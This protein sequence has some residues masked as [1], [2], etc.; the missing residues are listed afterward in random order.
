MKVELDFLQRAYYANLL[1]IRAAKQRSIAE[2]RSASATRL[3][4]EA[5]A[6]WC[7]A[8]AQRLDDAFEEK[9]VSDKEPIRIKDGS[10]VDI[11]YIDDKRVNGS[12][13]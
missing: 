12:G 13:S 6:Q 9:S 11:D 10:N 3:E 1:R 4:L 5:E 8:Q 7:E 2:G